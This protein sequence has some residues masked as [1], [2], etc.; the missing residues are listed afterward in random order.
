[1][2]CKRISGNFGCLNLQGIDR[3]ICL[4]GVLAGLALGTGLAGAGD[5]TEPASRP[6]IVVILADDLG[7]GD[8]GCYGHPWFKT[9]NLDRMAGEGVRLTQFNTPTPFCAPTRAA[10]MTGRYPFRCGLTTNPDPDGGPAADKTA[11]P[12]GEFTLA[13]LLRDR[14]ATLLRAGHSAREYTGTARRCHAPGPD[15][16][17]RRCILC[18]AGETVKQPPPGAWGWTP[19]WP[20]A[21]VAAWRTRMLPSR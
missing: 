13:Q 19:G 6:N 17:Q 18:R 9:P 14:I 1:M 3:M 16:T 12:P 15:R 10:L 2:N 7:N 8:L 11:L 4:S 5:R 21:S 20:E